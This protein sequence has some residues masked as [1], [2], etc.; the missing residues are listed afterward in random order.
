MA[1]KFD[2]VI[3]MLDNTALVDL[4]AVYDT[5]GGNEAQIAIE[6]AGALAIML[7][8]KSAYLESRAYG[9]EHDGAVKESNKAATAVREALGWSC[10][11][12][13]IS[14]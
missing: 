6:I 2:A 12:Q 10:P 13:Y 5:L 7:I 4:P 1:A 14:F 3:V 8:R 9:H 11:A